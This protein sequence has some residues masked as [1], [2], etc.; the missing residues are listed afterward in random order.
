MR[1]SRLIAGVALAV[2]AMVLPQ[3]T[4]PAS[5]AVT[6][7]AC[8]FDLINFNACL[9]FTEPTP[10][11][12]DAHVG[13]DAK[14]PQRYAQEIVAFGGLNTQAQL[15]STTGRFIVDL[16]VVSGS[17]TAGPTGLSA[18]FLATGLLRS[19]LNINPGAGAQESFFVQVS[20]FDFHGQ[21]VWKTF[22]TGTV[23]A[24]FAPR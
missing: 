7:L 10:N 24:D 13:L 16:P 18:R 4:V 8:N 17:P 15:F 1:L 23:T 12:L 3:A 5:A 21:G 22:R 2:G 6:D 20:Y 19:D 9:N 14:M 11:V